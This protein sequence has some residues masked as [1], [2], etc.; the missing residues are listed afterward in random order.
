MM[1]VIGIFRD[2]VNAPKKIVP[3]FGSVILPKW[4]QSKV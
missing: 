4:N 1:K 3:N 2:D